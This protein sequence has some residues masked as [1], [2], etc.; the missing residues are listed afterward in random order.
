MLLTH[1]EMDDPTAPAGF[2]TVF[3]KRQCMHCDEPACVAACPVTALEKTAEGPVVYDANKCIGCRYCM[4][5]CPFGAISSDW[6]SLAP[7][8]SKCTLCSDRLPFD[9]PT[10]RNGEKLSADE[11]QRSV[12]GHSMPA[13]VQTCPAD[14]LDF[15]DRDVMLAKA[16]DRI[17]KSNGKY[18]DHI[19]GEKEAGG[20]ATLYLSSV[21]FEKLGMPDVGTESYPARSIPA[22]AA[23]PPAVVGVGA[24]LGALSAWAE[25]P[26]AVAAAGSNSPQRGVRCSRRSSGPRQR[27]A[28]LIMASAR[29][30][31]WPASSLG[32]GGSTRLS[33]RGAGDSGS[34]D[35]V[36][37][38]LAAS[39][40][41]T[42]AI[43]SRVQRKDLY[44]I[45]R[46]AVHRAAQLLLRHRTL[47]ADLG[48]LA[49]LAARGQSPEHSAMFEVS[50]CVSLTSPSSSSSSCPSSSSGSVCSGR[51]SAGRRQP[52]VG[53]SSRSP[54]SCGSSRATCL[55]ALHAA[56]FA[57][58]LSPWSSVRGKREIHSGPARDR[59]VTL[60]TMPELARL[61]LYLLVPNRARPVWWSP[62][63]PIWFFLSAIAAGLSRVMLV[64]M[65]VAAWGRRL[66]MEQ[67][68]VVGQFT[69]W[70]LLVYGIVR[71]GDLA[72]RGQL[73]A[74]FTGPKAPFFLVEFVVGLVIPVLLLAT[75]KLRENPRALFFGALLG[76]VGVILNRTNV[77]IYALD[78][79]G[80]IPSWVPEPYSPSVYEWGL[81]I[82]LIAA[83]I[84]LYGLAVRKMPILVKEEGSARVN[85][86]APRTAAR[87]PDS[88]SYFFSS[89]FSSLSTPSSSSTSGFVSPTAAG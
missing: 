28:R 64:G 27:A 84:F 89:C 88:G 73:G 50:W 65:W 49:R 6:S 39:A 58:A 31:S 46:S 22:L 38:A 29:S 71:L 82:G 7:K 21:P 85:H 10:E 2:Q 60:S 9:A 15:G 57:A 47:L 33:S 25:A 32:L 45:G 83:A 23:V 3:V 18:V 76:C 19:W 87:Q 24:L 63:M 12:T 56:L 43:T 69:F 72:V 13:C 20:T 68:T 51:W 62:V 30:R 40:S 66:R 4:L 34:S 11:L 67:L 37:I 42:A 70:A 75:R 5:A 52:A 41:A 1:H 78:L 54:C 59:G 55:T 74:A 48:L 86:D 80:P 61:S 79:K 44:S 77:V 81:S 36:W 35:L 16:R 53:W 8:V 14:A 17:A 26:S